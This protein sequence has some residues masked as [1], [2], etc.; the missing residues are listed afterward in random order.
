MASVRYYSVESETL[1]PNQK[2]VAEGGRMGIY[3]NLLKLFGE[4]SFHQLAHR[5]VQYRESH[6]E[7][8]PTEQELGFCLLRLV[9][10]GLVGMKGV[11]PCVNSCCSLDNIEKEV[12]DDDDP[13]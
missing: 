4:L 11:G 1:T 9:E 2:I 12:E 6:N 5:I 13:R 8:I 7:Q 3:R 10:E